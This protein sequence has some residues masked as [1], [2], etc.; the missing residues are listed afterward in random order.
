MTIFT[1]PYQFGV[2]N[3]LGSHLLLAAHS[4][5]GLLQLSV[6]KYS[7]TSHLSFFICSAKII[8]LVLGHPCMSQGRCGVTH[9]Y[10]FAWEGLTV[11]LMASLPPHPFPREICTGLVPIPLFSFDQYWLL[12]CRDLQC[13]SEL[14]RYEVQ[15][16]ALAALCNPVQIKTRPR[17]RLRVDVQVMF[18]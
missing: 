4:I 15:L 11:I 3:I 14:I 18:W 8:M 9:L 17:F 2:L 12:F 6:P 5:W 1:F 7:S 13:M 16:Q 10:I